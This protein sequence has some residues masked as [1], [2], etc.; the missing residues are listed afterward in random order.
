MRK[1]DKLFWR[2]FG[3]ILV[4]VEICIY[5]LFI[6]NPFPWQFVRVAFML[7]NLLIVAYLVQLKLKV[8]KHNAQVNRDHKVNNPAANQVLHLLRFFL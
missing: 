3:S 7:V 2:Y 5:L 1:K 4:L 8:E 6:R